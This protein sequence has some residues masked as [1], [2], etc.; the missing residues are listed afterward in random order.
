MSSLTQHRDALPFTP[1]RLKFDYE[2]QVVLFN[3]LSFCYV[4]EPVNGSWDWQKPEGFHLDSW[5]FTPVKPKF[6]CEWSVVLDN[7]LSFWFPLNLCY[8]FVTCRFF[9]I[10]FVRFLIWFYGIEI[11]INLLFPF[12]SLSHDQKKRWKWQL[13]F[14]YWIWKILT[15]IKSNL[16]LNDL[17]V[18]N[19]L[20][21]WEFSFIEFEVKEKF[22]AVNEKSEKTKWK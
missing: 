21:D 3:E 10:L 9:D 22:S 11:S 7:E 1:V 15:E 19:G 4:T 2:R 17:C 14:T 6:D 12:C 18:L 20:C 8:L 16:F 13:I 5:P